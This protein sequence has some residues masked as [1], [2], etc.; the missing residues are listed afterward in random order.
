MA[1]I[2]IEKLLQE[3]SPDSPSGEDVEYDPAFREMVNAALP[4]PPPEFGPDKD[5]PP[6]PPDWR[7]VQQK[8]LELLARSK[9]LRPAVY[10]SRALLDSQGFSGLRDGLRLLRGLLERYWKTCYPQL[11]PA[12]EY[13]PSR[14]NIIDD[15]NSSE[16]ML[17][18]IRRITLLD[19]PRLGRFNVRDINLTDKVVKLP[20]GPDKQ[21][22]DL[23]E[24]AA[25]FI[26]K[27]GEAESIQT[28]AS[29]VRGCIAAVRDCMDGANALQSYVAEQA[30]A[31]NAPQL[32]DLIKALKEIEYALQQI[33]VTL[34]E[35][36][37]QQGIAEPL[38]AGVAETPGVSDP[39]S[40]LQPA[41]PLVTGEVTSRDDVIRWLD[42]LCEYFKR[43]EPSSPVPILLRRAKR[44]VSKDF[45][46]IVRDLAPESVAQFE[47]IRGAESENTS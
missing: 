27:R 43:S 33:D 17:N 13:D 31:A 30:G 10:L 19:L 8:A 5:N 29:D 24:I 32:D 42:K 7:K 3:V 21:L 18:D 44:L 16:F 12:D 6:E 37:A 45:M 39:D 34:A 26:E 9:H 2:D 22:T 4:K 25:D 11:D 28:A 23:T 35:Q 47:Y 40:G 20:A 15:L 1:V 41:M 36:L 14:R 46:E 38:P